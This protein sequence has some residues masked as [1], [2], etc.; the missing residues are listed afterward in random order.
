M[1]FHFPHSCH[2]LE[3]ISVNIEMYSNN[4][5]VWVLH[6]RN[7]KWI[8]SRVLWQPSSQHSRCRSC[9]V[10]IF[11]STFSFNFSYCITIILFILLNLSFLSFSNRLESN[12]STNMKNNKKKFRG[13]DALR[14]WYFMTWARMKFLIFRWEI[15]SFF[16]WILGWLEDM[17]SEVEVIFFQ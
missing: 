3:V 14:C 7:L 4:D 1:I 5:N 10:R 15:V 9:D 12:W 11:I 2:K 17:I 16:G 8:Q 6:V 13:S